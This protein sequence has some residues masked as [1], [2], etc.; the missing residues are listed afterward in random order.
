MFEKWTHKWLFYLMKLSYKKQAN[1]QICNITG[2][3]RHRMVAKIA[4]NVQY[5]RKKKPLEIEQ[6]CSC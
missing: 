5:Q 3:L 6:C 2:F 4:F 1:V